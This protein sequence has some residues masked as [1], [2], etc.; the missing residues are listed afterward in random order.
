M[1]G[2]FQDDNRGLLLIVITCCAFAAC[3]NA[4]EYPSPLQTAQIPSS[5]ARAPRLASF[6][7]QLS[8]NLVAFC[9][10]VNY[11]VF[12]T[13]LLADLEWQIIDSK[14]AQEYARL[15]TCSKSA[16]KQLV[17]A[18]AFPQCNIIGSASVPVCTT[19]CRD[20]YGSCPQDSSRTVCE[21]MHP[22]AVV[23][24]RYSTANSCSLG[25]GNASVSV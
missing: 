13:R 10:H 14:A 5:V 16:C 21:Q 2:L 20:C 25:L 15:T 3:I 24:R 8:P 12:S 22:A 19:L 11:P 18:N 23:V 7:T 17:C 4:Q 1:S 6:C 9:S